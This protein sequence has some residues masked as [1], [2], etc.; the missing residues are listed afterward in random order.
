MVM[1]MIRRVA[2]THELPLTQGDL[3]ICQKV[4]DHV[5]GQKAVDNEEMREQL[6]AAIIHSYQD[7]VTDPGALLRLFS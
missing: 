1:T 5:A 3:E 7:G 4:F 6:A 2:S